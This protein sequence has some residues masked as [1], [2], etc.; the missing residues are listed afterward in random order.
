MGQA[1][2]VSVLAPDIQP[3]NFHFPSVTW[4]RKHFS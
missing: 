2:V 1:F 4:L 3:A